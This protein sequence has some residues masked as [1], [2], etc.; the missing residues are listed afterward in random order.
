MKYV[1]YSVHP[2]TLNVNVH[3]FYNKY[4]DAVNSFSID[5]EDYVK[6]NK[7]ITFIEFLNKK[8]DVNAKSDGYYLKTSN[9]YPNRINLYEKRTND[10]GYIFSNLVV[11]VK[12]IMVFSLLE[13]SCIPDTLQID[14]EVST[15]RGTSSTKQSQPR[16]AMLY[17]DELK[18]KLK[19]I[20]IKMNEDE[21]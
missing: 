21:L 11:N 13:L 3:N 1:N 19:D 10:V 17:F 14:A 12:K 15:L 18:D 9:K 4:T 8:K 6:K 7:K 2:N 16:I 5:V 20:R